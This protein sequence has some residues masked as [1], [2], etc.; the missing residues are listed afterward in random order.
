MP[1]LPVKSL[2]LKK[3]QTENLILGIHFLLLK[4]CK[5]FDQS[6]KMSKILEKQFLKQRN[7]FEKSCV[8]RD[9][10]YHFPQGVIFE[11]DIAYA[12]DKNKA[13]RLDR[14]RPKGKETQILPV[15]INVHGGGLLL[16]N[17][18]FN[19]YFC[20]LLSKKGFLVYSTEYRLI[21]DCTFFDQLRDIFLAMDF[22]KEHAAAD[23]GDLRMSILTSEWKKQNQI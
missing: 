9:K 2:R 17:K 5:I 8:E 14:Y 12:K 6:I 1:H 16:G 22:V 3:V 19:K 15:I 18:E 21:P 10:K 11:T 13:H 4:K 23:G 20:A 7:D